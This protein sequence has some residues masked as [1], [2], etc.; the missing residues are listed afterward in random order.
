MPPG[1]RPLYSFDNS[2]VH[3][4]ANSKGHMH[5]QLPTDGGFSD[6]SDDVV[7]QVHDR[8]NMYNAPGAR[9]MRSGQRMDSE[10]VDVPRDTKEAEQLLEQAERVEEGVG[11]V[12]APV[13]ML[14][15]GSQK[16]VKSD[17]E[18]DARQR[19][20]EVRIREAIAETREAESRRKEAESKK[21]DAETQLSEAESQRQG[22]TARRCEAE[23]LTRKLVA[24]ARDAEARTRE[25]ETRTREAETEAGEAEA[26][27]SEAAA[28]RNWV[29]SQ[30]RY[31]TAWFIEEE[32]R[33]EGIAH[34]LGQAGQSSEAERLEVR[35]EVEP[36]ISND[37]PQKEA[38]VDS[39]VT[40]TTKCKT[41]T[42]TMEAA[43]QTTEADTRCK[44]EG[45]RR[46]ESEGFRLEERARQTLAEAEWLEAGA[47]QVD[48]SAKMLEAAAQQ[49]EADAT[50]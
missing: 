32:A 43:V 48:A 17:H 50:S 14:E 23:A 45:L 5:T 33:M 28:Q 6:A 21:R 42:H 38:V 1:E 25:A 27:A 24:Q 16:E 8:R 26:Q 31:I 49:K 46:R 15:V 11:Q 22:A 4:W 7:D 2:N 19:K 20:A 18:M 30:Y 3:R 36:K 10:Q 9:T 40:D 13:N 12:D 37:A 44:E 35:L 39:N 29:E 34:F 47:R 41:D